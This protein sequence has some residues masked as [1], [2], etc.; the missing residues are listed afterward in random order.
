MI[1]CLCNAISEQDI[2]EAIEAGNICCKDI[3]KH[4]GYDFDCASCCDTIKDIIGEAC[5]NQDRQPVTEFGTRLESEQ[6][7]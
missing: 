6:S 2:K 1:V 7:G 4:L 5:N 3:M